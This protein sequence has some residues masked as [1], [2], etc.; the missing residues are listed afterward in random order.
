MGDVKVAA[1]TGS[2]FRETKRST[3][4]GYGGSWHCAHNGKWI[5]DMVLNTD[6]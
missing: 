4:G 5:A 1:C 2:C 6:D 3:G